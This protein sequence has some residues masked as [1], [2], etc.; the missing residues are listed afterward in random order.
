MID[1]RG[2]NLRHVKNLNRNV[3]L[4]LIRANGPA[5]KVEI[6]ET[7]RLTFTAINNI[8]DELL[9]ERL[10]S[11]VG[12]DASSGGRKPML[13]DINPNV[14]YTIG[15]HFSASTIKTAVIN[16]KGVS[17]AEES[18]KLNNKADRDTIIGDIFDAIERIISKSEIARNR[19]VCIGV[20]S[21]GPLN[22][23]RGVILSPP[24]IPG[25]QDVPLGELL[26]QKFGIR[27]VLEK[28]ANAM[29]LSELW[30]GS[31]RDSNNVIYVDAD[32]GIGSGIIFNRKIYQGFPFGAG[33][34]GHGTI[35]LD[36]P[37][38][39]CG[40]YGCL[41]AVASGMAVI[42]RAGEEIRRGVE[43][44]LADL[45]FADEEA[46]DIHAVISAARHQDVLAMNLLNESARYVGIA[47]ANVI[48]LLIPET[49]II[50]G[51]LVNEYPEYFNQVK[52]VAL[53]RCFSTLTKE[54][55]LQPSKLKNQAGVIGAGTLGLERYL[56]DI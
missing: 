42:R 30:Y 46:L 15:V 43:S 11:K 40:N 44:E 29:A 51:L 12:F 18:S 26:Q 49:M 27:A 9:N 56:A 16:F 3:I 22:P 7:T 28:D 32:I 4:Q 55:M 23:N 33:E 19:F 2:K 38:C 13:L 35:D 25:L 14:V 24:N 45:Y 17:I 41:E 52:S 31:G 10:I 50:G 48:N 1:N 8:V 21:P 37:R 34:I 20:A 6:A 36:G 47:L 54:T 5:T 53:S 39:N